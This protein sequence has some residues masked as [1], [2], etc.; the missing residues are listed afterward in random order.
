M[1]QFQEGKMNKRDAILL[2]TAA[3]VAVLTLSGDP[4]QGKPLPVKFSHPDLVRFDHDCFTVHGK[5]IFI[6]SGSFHYFRCDSS[7]WMDR[8]EKIKAA[9]FNTVET[10]IPWNWHEQQEGQ[11]DFTPLEKFLTD[12]EHLGFYVIVRPGPYIC[13][14]WDVGGFPEWLAGKGMGF[15]TSSQEDIRW[16]QYWYNEVLP[17]IR[18]HLIT[19]GGSIIMMQ[20]EN[21]YD[22]FDLPDSDKAVYVKSLY[23]TAIKNG[24]DVPIITCWTKQTREKTDSVFSQ[25]LDACNFYPGWNIEGTLQRIEKAKTEEPNSPPMITELQGGWFSSVGDKSVRDL[26]SYGP[27]Q[28]NAL[29]KYVI[30]H[31][32]KALNYYMLYG[33]TNFG[34]WGS[35]GRTTSYDYTAPISEPGGLWDKYRNVKLIGDFIRLAGQYLARSHEVKGGATTQSKG[36]ECLLRSDGNVSFLFVRNTNNGP[37]EAQI[38]VRPPR[39]SQFTISI[40]M[41]ARDAYFLPVN[42]PLPG[43][44]VLNYTNVQVSAVTEYN[45]KPLI[46][47]YGNEGDEAKIYAG[48]SMCSETI[49]SSDQLF[50]WDGLYVLLTTKERGARTQVYETPSGPVVLISNTYFTLPNESRHVVWDSSPN[51]H[52]PGSA[53]GVQV[54]LQTRPGN[55][56]FSLVAPRNLDAVTIDGKRPKAVPTGRLGMLEFSFTTPQPGLGNIPISNV[57]YKADDEAANAA[58]LTEIKVSGED[59]PSLDSLRDFQSGYTIYSGNFTLGEKKLLKFDYYDDDWHAVYVDGKLITDLT[60]NSEENIATL[61]LPQGTHE[62]KIVYEN[63]G[64]QNG[65]FMEQEKGLKRISAYLPGQIEYL[66]KWKYSPTSSA[67]PEKEPAESALSFDDS[68]WPEVNVGSSQHSFIREHEGWWFRK[69]ISLSEEAVNGKPELTFK[70]IDDSALVYVNGSLAGEHK[71]SGELFSI[72]IGSLAKTGE[73]VIAVCVQNLAGSEGIFKSVVLKWGNATQ[74]KASLLFHHSLDGELAGWQDAKLDDSN[75]K[76]A[77]NWK[78]GSSSHLITC[79]RGEFTLPNREGWTI[80]WRLHVESTGDMQIWLNGRLLGRYFSKGP[81]KDFYVPG[82]TA[83]LIAQGKNTVALVLRPSGSGII[84]PTIKSVYVA[85]YDE[86]VTQEHTLNITFK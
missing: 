6:Y 42:Y 44:K 65:G 2:F 14:E 41:R 47:A 23:E 24:I 37:V 7:L 27:D 29:T 18:R 3:L 39:A 80:P 53:N 43:G 12:C 1:H 78:P 36:V 79:Y 13:A 49:K 61:D 32:V 25:I 22:Y 48:E 57:R 68:K 54:N 10:Y 59:Y 40:K 64:R 83:W 4:Q 35:K 33:G 55:D 28:I 81:Q 86:Y 50:D 31:G 73:N 16:S 71:G 19:N 17:V 52:G 69:H 82:S 70:G 77:S 72:P 74:L 26:E 51:V 8:L 46:I 63:E 75:W 38:D 56:L 76:T 58:G 30:A 45:G 34:Y 67:Y 11:A 85:P 84:P 15:R 21:E 60:G 62:I 66:D 20:I 9:G 5:D